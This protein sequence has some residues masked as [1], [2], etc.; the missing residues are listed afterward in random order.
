MK[1]TIYILTGV[2]VVLAI[3]LIAILI[4]MKNQPPQTRGIEPMV[5]IAPM[6]PDSSKWG[7]N[8]PNQYSTLLKTEDN[9]NRT[10]FGGSEPY[11]KLEQDPRLVTLFAGYSFSKD[12]DED[13]GH[14]N[15]LTDVRATKR[16]NEITPGTCYS[17]KSS[18]NPSLWK[19]MGMEEYDHTPFAELG[20]EIEQPIGC[21]N[22]HEENTM[23]LI[24]TNP[25][26]EQALKKQGLD[27]TKFTR[28]EMR[29]AVC[30]NCHVEYYFAG[31]GK[32]LTFPWENGRKI[33][34]IAKY[35]QEEGF[36]DWDHPDSGAPMI[37]MQHPEFEFYTNESTH[38]MAGVACA[39]CHMPYTRDGAAKFSNHNVQSPLLNADAACG[40]CH[41]DVAYVTGRVATIQA[42]VR[43]TMDATEDA[44]VA[45]IAVIKAAAASANVDT[46]QLDEA[47]NLHREAQLR[48]DFIA[49]ENSMG[50]H[51]PEEA[52]RILAD[53]TNL[54]RQA[55]LKAVQAA[56][57]PQVIQTSD[58]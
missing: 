54:A 2:I 15:S 46:K 27:W 31:E 47:R 17:C 51:N 6:E 55:E 33:E 41:T 23:R 42:Q 22:C 20:K 40:Q 24:V 30:G 4:F 12:Y 35:Y 57:T 58:Q 53:A 38:F 3:G 37:K 5:V 28:Q 45:A 14:M 18:N 43:Q 39:D 49:A 19:K 26:F 13:R 21:A 34:D 52:L 11:S 8:F 44:I 1:R 10:T 16:V 9:N 7:V 29:T 32:Y 56:G 50:F 25:A 36:K 48:W